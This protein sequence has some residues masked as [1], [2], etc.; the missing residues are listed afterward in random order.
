LIDAAAVIKAMIEMRAEM[1]ADDERAKALNLDPDEL[2]FYDV[3]AANYATL[4]EP[5]FLR[6]LIHDVVQTLKKNLKVDWTAE[7]RQQVQSQIRAAVKRTL[8][9]HGVKAEHLEPISVRIMEQ[10]AATFRDW[11][12]LAA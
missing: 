4:Y 2:A 1:N 8:Q 5:G 11:P 7:H 3:V 6:D 9:R 10:A 12:I